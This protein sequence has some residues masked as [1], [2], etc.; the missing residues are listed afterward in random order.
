MTRIP[1]FYSVNEVKKTADWRRYHDNDLCGP[2]REIPRPDRRPGKGGYTFCGDC[3]K[4][5]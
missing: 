5:S 2:G 1:D 3:Q 4:L